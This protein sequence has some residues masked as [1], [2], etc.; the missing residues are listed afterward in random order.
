MSDLVGT[1]AQVAERLEVDEAFVRDLI[2]KREIPHV[3]LGPRK[4]IVPWRALD[5]WLTTEAFQNLL[6]SPCGTA[7]DLG[8][9]AD[10]TNPSV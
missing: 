6:T 4:V 10:T 3:R 5:D 9:V 2:N 1:V 8:L 7:P